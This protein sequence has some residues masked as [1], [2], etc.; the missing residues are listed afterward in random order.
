MSSSYN[1]F[2]FKDKEIKLGNWIK[3][4]PDDISKKYKSRLVS[5][6]LI[7]NQFKLI[8]YFFTNLISDFFFLHSK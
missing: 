1:S 6:I 5:I 8:N 4:I 7:K 2:N 3:K